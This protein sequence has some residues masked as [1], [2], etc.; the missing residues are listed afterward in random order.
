MWMQRLHSNIPSVKWGLTRGVDQDIY[1][2]RTLIIHDLPVR[3]FGTTEFCL[4]KMPW[5]S[6]L[7]IS[8]IVR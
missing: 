7:K 6:I 1:I 3:S 4:R 8:L 2:L 5:S